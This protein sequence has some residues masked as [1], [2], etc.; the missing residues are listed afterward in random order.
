MSY[1]EYSTGFRGGGFGPRPSDAYQVR[2]FAPEDLRSYE[3]GVKSDEFDHMLTLNGAVFY[4]IYTNQQIGFN[5]IQPAGTPGA[6]APWFETVNTGKSDMYGFEGEFVAR[7]ITNMLL[8]GSFGYLHY[9]RVDLGEAAGQLLAKLPNGTVVYP[10]QTP[11]FNASIGAQYEIP[12]GKDGSDG[13]LTPR[14]DWH[15]QSAVF[16]TS[17]V[18]IGQ[19]AYSTVDARLTWQTEDRKWAVSAYGTNITNTYYDYGKLSLQSVLG[20]EQ[21]NPAP[22][23][24]WGLSVKR[25]F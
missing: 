22:P 23:A 3:V 15:W 10:P 6:G 17:A 13:S 7:P 24:E 11:E 1:A 18:A 14:V 21:A 9:Y 16:F 19:D 12:L 4:S 20:F 25:S 8:Q 2:S 5:T